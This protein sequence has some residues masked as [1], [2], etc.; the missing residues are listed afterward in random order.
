MTIEDWYNQVPDL[1][2]RKRLS[3][4]IDRRSR[5][6]EIDSLVGAIGGGFTW[7]KTPEGSQYWKNIIFRYRD[8]KPK[9]VI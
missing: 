7:T 6:E 4:L 3:E 5:E 9:S 1:N 2:L 8:F